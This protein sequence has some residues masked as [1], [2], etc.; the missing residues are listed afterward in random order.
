MLF[1]KPIKTRRTLLGGKSSGARLVVFAKGI[2]AI[3]SAQK[4]IIKKNAKT[5]NLVRGFAEIHDAETEISTV[6]RK[7]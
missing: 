7:R 5:V 3:T 2:K 6:V 4:A 1:S